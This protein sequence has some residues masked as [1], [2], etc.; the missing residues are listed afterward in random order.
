M[1]KLCFYVCC[2]CVLS[3][4]WLSWQVHRSLAVHIK[5]SSATPFQQEFQRL[6]A[7]S[8]PVAGFV[9]FIPLPQTLCSTSRAA[10]DDITG[11]SK[12]KSN[13]TKNSK[14]SH[15]EGSAALQMQGKPPQSYPPLFRAVTSVEKYTVGTVRTMHDARTNVELLE[16]NPN[17]MRSHL[18][19]FNQTHFSYVQPELAGLTIAENSAGV[20]DLNSPH[21]PSLQRIILTQSPLTRTSHLDQPDVGTTQLFFQQRNRNM[22]TH[23]AGLNALQRQWKCSLNFNS[24][25]ELPCENLKLLYSPLQ[26]SQEKTIL[27]FPFTHLR[28]HD[29]GRQTSLETR[30]QDQPPLQPRPNTEAVTAGRGT[31]LSSQLQRD[32]LLFLPGAKQQL[33]MNPPPGLKWTPQ[34]HPNAAHPKMLALHSSFSTNHGTRQTTRTQLG[35]RPFQN[36]MNARLE[37]SQSM[38]ERRAAGFSSN[39]NQT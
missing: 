30:R 4:S 37:R 12:Q 39:R 24:K 15:K 35:W 21:T 29:S 26:Q 16:K 33:H 8:K 20:Q 3:F 2:V 25:V 11:S 17:R 10:L 6:H 34:N 18:T 28:G 31:L 1:Y 14:N 22:L 36:G 5:G 19:P 27:Q 23:P 32:S 13:Q 9:T 38:T 7:D